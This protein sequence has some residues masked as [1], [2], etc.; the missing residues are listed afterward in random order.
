MRIRIDNKLPL[1]GGALLLCIGG[2][3]AVSVPSS[4]ADADYGVPAT[5][6]PRTTQPSSPSSPR[7]RSSMTMPYFSFAQL[8]RPRS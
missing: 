4:C 1:F 8:L 2:W 3:V 5:E 6:N 7:L